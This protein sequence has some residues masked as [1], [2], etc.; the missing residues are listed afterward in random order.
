MD[1]CLWAYNYVAAFLGFIWHFIQPIVSSPTFIAALLASILAPWFA[2]RTYLKQ[3]RVSR[4]QRIYY[5]ESL[6]NQ[7]K[8][9]DDSIDITSKNLAY[10]ENAINLILNNFRMGVVTAS[11]ITSLNEI[12][13]KIEAPVRYQSSKKEVLIILFQKYGYIA[14]QWLFKCDNDFNW[15]NLHIREEIFNLATRLQL[16]PN[17]PETTI[18]EQGK[19]IDNNFNLVMRHYT[20]AYFFNQLVSRV[21]ILDFKSQKELINGI[22]NDNVIN[23]TLTKMDEAFKILFGYFKIDDKNFISYLK[24]ENGDRFKIHINDQIS[25][26]RMNE[27]IPS[28]NQMRIIKDDTR[29][30]NV[31]VNVN[32]SPRSYSLIQTGMANL[33][34]FDEKP[35]FY[36]EAESFDRFE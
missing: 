27:N 18:R 15:F 29:L 8:H 36:L 14:H 23:S 19:E 25:I 3:Q 16:T 13:N 20:F 28:I 2:I 30:A 10:F 31:T 7:L 21:G 26:E 5:E 9:L 4:I 24:D 12:A 33:S 35:K 34:T 17:L 1:Y 11:T 22:K 6:L 32:N